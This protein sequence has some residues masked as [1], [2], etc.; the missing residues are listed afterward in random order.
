MKNCHA[1]LLDTVSIQEYIFQSNKLKENLGAS[2]LVEEVYRSCLV[3]A[4]K[5]VFPDSSPDLESWKGRPAEPP[6]SKALFDIGYIG[7]GNALLFFREQSK[8]DEFV[9]RWTMRLLVETPGIVTA[10]A[11]A[12]FDPDDF[13][14]ERKNLFRSLRNNKSRYSPQT[15]IPRHGITGPCTRT[16]LSLDKWNEK[17]NPAAYVSS[18]A[19]AKIE[20]SKK[21]Q[22]AIHEDFNAVLADEQGP[23]VFP[24]QLEELGRLKGE[25]SHIAV[26]HIDGNDMG[27]R[28]KAAKTLKDARELSVSV[29]EATRKSF[30]E[31]VAHIVGNYRIIMEFLGFDQASKDKKRRY[32]V[33]EE[34]QRKFLP[35][36]PI[37]LGGDDIT[38]VC[39]GRLGLYFAK[40]FMER[41][42]TRRA[43]DNRPLSCCAGV[44]I[45]K[46]SYPFYRGCRLA[47]ELCKS[48]KDA[49]REN[50]DKGPY[51]DFHISTG[52]LSGGL[53]TIRKNN[54]AVS[55]GSLLFRPYKL[56]SANDPRS[57]DLCVAN[58]GTL[59]KLPN[60]KIH[61]LRRVLTLSRQE[62]LRFIDELTYRDERE[63]LAEL[64]GMDCAGDLFCDNKTPY[65]DMIEVMEYY[66]DFV[67]PT[68]ERQ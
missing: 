45:T 23:F 40:Y 36:R 53:D 17:A 39:D 49:R 22:S 32:P 19:N 52:G 1:V 37:I 13:K 12:P 61:E 58:A 60:N 64:P 30:R 41:F 14:S 9:N 57:F 56:T 68:E 4:L 27:E 47:E 25:E 31:L 62:A 3:E 26:V 63:K 44:A 35:I 8:A 28:F 33:D 54:Y 65:F 66:P 6:L 5:E 29:D 67:W 59:R 15:V 34:T 24:D 48:A 2:H 51:L 21:A 42:G 38:F 43:S 46:T 10:V 16:G 20:A 55:R 11:S 50:G 18:V 7:G